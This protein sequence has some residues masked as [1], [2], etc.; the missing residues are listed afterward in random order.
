[1]EDENKINQEEQYYAA[2]QT[3]L[4]DILGVAPGWLLRSGISVVAI[5]LMILLIGSMLFRYPDVIEAQVVVV[6]D[7]PP[8]NLF[9]VTNGKLERLFKADGSSIQKGD[10]IAVSESPLYLDD[11]LSLRQ[12]LQSKITEDYL[13]PADFALQNLNLGALQN[14]YND[15]LKA[16]YDWQQ[17]LQMHYHSQRIRHLNAQLSER[18]QMEEQIKRQHESYQQIYQLV[19]RNYRRDSL[20]FDQQNIALLDFERTKS[21][22]IARRINLEDYQSQL[23]NLR[24]QKNDL[25]AS[26]LE[27]QMDFD[28]KKAELQMRLQSIYEN[29]KSH[30]LQWERTYAF[31]APISGQ[32]VYASGWTEN[33]HINSGNLVFSIIPEDYGQFL[34]RGGIPLHGSGKVKTGNRVNIRLSNYPYQEYGVL[35]GEVCHISQVP[36]DALFPIQVSLKNQLNTSYHYNLGNHVVLEG[37]AQIITEDISLFNRMMNPLR[38]LKRNG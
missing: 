36:S 29:L 27:T 23:I 26:L 3:P 16:S 25:Q 5:L 11:V 31:V 2:D 37:A 6:A 9:A 32:L 22:F 24:V 18:E 30:L 21:D 7:N 15:W 13:I 17:F 1:M 33:Q 4:N 12:I 20:L 8:L 14:P 35:Q 19:E 38:S 10:I 34:A 28:Q